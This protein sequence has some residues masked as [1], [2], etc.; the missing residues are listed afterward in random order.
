MSDRLS[1][2][3]SHLCAAIRSITDLARLLEAVRYQSGLGKSQWERVERARNVA[4]EADQFL[5]S[6]VVEGN[7]TKE[8]A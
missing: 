1:K 3:D 7:Q 6:L 2:M 5:A 4:A 8:T